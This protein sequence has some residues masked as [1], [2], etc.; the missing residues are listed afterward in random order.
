MS[1]K[2][3]CPYRQ[4]QLNRI[5]MHM[6]GLYVPYFKIT[7]FIVHSRGFFRGPEGEKK[8]IGGLLYGLRS[9]HAEDTM[10]SNSVIETSASAAD[11]AGCHPRG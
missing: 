1:R 3:F 6:T 11:W 4:Q 8:K 5:R 7:C 9:L 2:P 10:Y